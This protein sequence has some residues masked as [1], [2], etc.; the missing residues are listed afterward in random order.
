M[1]F[2]NFLTHI[3]KRT[4]PCSLEKQQAAAWGLVTEYAMNLKWQKLVFCLDTVRVAWQSPNT[5]WGSAFLPSLF[6][7][8]SG[9]YMV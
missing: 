7:G 3:P 9:C 1:L 5:L 4:D 6:L 2:F 8:Q